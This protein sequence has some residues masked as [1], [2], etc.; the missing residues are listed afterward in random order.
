H[1]TPG[2]TASQDGMTRTTPRR[3]D[4]AMFASEEGPYYR[5]KESWVAFR[6][7]IR[8][9]AL[10]RQPVA[11]RPPPFPHTNQDF[12]DSGVYIF[13]RYDVQI[14]G[15]TKCD[16]PSDPEGGVAE[17]GGIEDDPRMRRG[18]QV[19][20]N[21]RDQQVPGSVYGVAIPSGLY[22]NRAHK[23]GEWNTLVIEFQP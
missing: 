17:G 3:P 15:P 6:L 9:R 20:P 14:S 5:T 23:T 13:D 16:S 12:S 22:I 19:V 11:P 7:T 18:G 21:N 1:A 10:D 8:Y 4:G 2:W